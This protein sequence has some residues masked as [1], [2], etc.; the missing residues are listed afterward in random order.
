VHHAP[1]SLAITGVAVEKLF[2]GVAVEKLFSGRF[3]NKI[4]S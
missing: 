3:S 1:A 2:T 4:C